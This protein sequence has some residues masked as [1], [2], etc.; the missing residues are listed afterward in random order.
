MCEQGRATADPEGEQGSQR[1]ALDALFRAGS[2]KGVKDLSST[3]SMAC[4]V[5]AG[6][7]LEPDEFMNSKKSHE[8]QSI[9]EVVAALAQRC[10]VK[11]VEGL[12]TACGGECSR[13]EP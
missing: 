13:C 8:V 10:G 3:M 11:Q 9:S 4:C 1:Y 5:A 12:L 6:V 2:W 7:E